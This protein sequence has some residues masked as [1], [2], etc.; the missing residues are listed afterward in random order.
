[1]LCMP[2]S[3]PPRFPNGDRT[4]S[5]T[6]TSPM[7]HSFSGPGAN[8]TL[9]PATAFT[10]RSSSVALYDPPPCRHGASRSRAPATSRT[11][12]ATRRPT[13]ARPDGAACTA[14]T[15]C[16]PSSGRRAGAARP[17]GAH[18]HRLPFRTSRLD[19]IGIGPL[20]EVSITHVHCPT[21]DGRRPEAAALRGRTAAEFY[22]LL[23]TAR[24]RTSPPCRRSRGPMRCPPSSSAWR[25]RIGPGCSPPWSSGFSVCPTT[26]SPTTCSPRTSWPRLARA[27]S[28][29]DGA[30]AE[31]LR[32]DDMPED[33]K[34]A[35]SH[36]MEELLRHMRAQWGSWEGYA[37]GIG[38]PE[39]VVAT[40][41]PARRRLTVPT[42]AF[43]VAE[44][45]RA[46]PYSTETE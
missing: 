4:A 15:R 16:T 23:T 44:H 19:E 9:R 34:G 38:F 28:R 3:P 18:R 35:H 10:R 25:A 27:A 39:G 21:F 30:R 36:V 12:A 45:G 31:T 5:T 17:R 46:R 42:P 33:L 13:A 1:M 26:S 6:T 11:S 24:L 2:D 22:A 14:A 41:A 43:G 29:R 40:L 32:W 7:T 20:G 37:A 8:G